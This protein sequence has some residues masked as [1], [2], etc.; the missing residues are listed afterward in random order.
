MATETERRFLVKNK[1]FI[2][3]S[4]FQKYRI[5]QG[6]LSDDPERIVRVRLQTGKATITIKG[7]KNE[8][9]GL[10]FEYYIPLTDAYLL[11]PLCKSVIDKT[12][13]YVN[14]DN[15]SPTWHSGVIRS[16]DKWEIDVFHGDNDGLIIAELEFATEDTTIHTIPD[17]IGEEITD[18][19]R[20]ANSNLA[21]YPYS[22]WKHLFFNV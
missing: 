22:T 18:D 20:Y 2:N 17:W 14:I 9:S 10:E 8:G 3:E 1:N 21:Q 12:R 16:I 6:Y 7:L 19:I 11:I 15:V 4:Q 5:T 13:Y